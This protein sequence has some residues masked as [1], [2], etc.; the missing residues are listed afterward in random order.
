M[1]H[2]TPPRR[3]TAEWPQARTPAPWRACRSGSRTWRTSPGCRHSW[4]PSRTRTVSPTT[5]ACRRPA[6]APPER[7]SSE[8]RRRPSSAQPLSP[9]RCCMARRATRGTPSGHREAPRAARRRPWPRPSCPSPR[10]PTAAAPS[11]S[12]RRTRV[13]SERRGRSAASPEAKGR[14]RRTRPT[15]GACR[16]PCG[17]PRA[18]GIAS[19]AATSATQPPSRIPA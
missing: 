13:C 7:S 16:A 18:G 15:S 12:R 1:A 8:R 14:S 10:A 3:S 17:T 2:A 6:C 9:E 4:V 5:T 11:A 19:S